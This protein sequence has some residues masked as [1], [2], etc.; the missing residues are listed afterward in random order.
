MGWQ[1]DD[2][3]TLGW[4]GFLGFPAG[5]VANLFSHG[6]QSTQWSLQHLLAA[7]TGTFPEC[8]ALRLS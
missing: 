3:A 6:E 2:T 1:W 4:E 5:P 7:P 8:W